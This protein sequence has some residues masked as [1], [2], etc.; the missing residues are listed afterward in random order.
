M[1]SEQQPS[2]DGSNP[3]PDTTI[4]DEQKFM[5]GQHYNILLCYLLEQLKGEV[6]IPLAYLQDKVEGKAPAEL[7]VVQLV[8]GSVLL[9]VESPDVK[10]RIELLS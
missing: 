6:V 9:K 2:P 1:T 5:E 3:V 7:T 4:G 8:D 10:G